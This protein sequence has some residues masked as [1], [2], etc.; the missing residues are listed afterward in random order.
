MSYFAADCSVAAPLLEPLSEPEIVP[1]WKKNCTKLRPFFMVCSAG[2]IYSVNTILSKLMPISSGQYV[3]I[4]GTFKFLV[5]LLICSFNGVNIWPWSIKSKKWWFCGQVVF[6]S[7]G[8]ILKIVV[9][10][11]MNIGDATAIIFSSPIWAVLLARLVLKEK[12]TLVNLIAIMLGFLGIILIAKPGF[13]FSEVSKLGEI[14]WSFLA[15]A[16]SFSLAISYVIVRG[17]GEVFHSVQLVLYTSVAQ[18]ITGFLCNLAL[19]ETLV[20]PPCNWVRYALLLCGLSAPL[21]SISLI[22]GLSLENSG[23][24]TMMRNFDI[25]YAYIFEVILFNNKPDWICVA[26]TCLIIFTTLL[27]G[28]D[29]IYDIS[30]NTINFSF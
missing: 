11:N 22:K 14:S 20:L 13:L 23:P 10:Q 24:A 3:I 12:F 18:I 2:L 29:K 16:A 21:A 1:S 15:L 30:R 17:A 7:I 5:A 25:V 8:H 19:K 9:V 4:E 28:I 6:S 26:G 27:Q